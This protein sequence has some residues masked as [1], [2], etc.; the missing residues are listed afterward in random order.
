MI[1]KIQKI[2][3]ARKKCVPRGIE[4]RPSTTTEIESHA[5]TN[6][7]TVGSPIGRG[8]ALYLCCCGRSGF[9]PAWDTFFSGTF[10]FHKCF[11]TEYCNLSTIFYFPFDLLFFLL[12]IHLQFHSLKCHSVQVSSVMYFSLPCGLALLGLRG[13]NLILRYW[14][15]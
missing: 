11:S 2:K 8:V 4:P 13:C 5:S 10:L 6:W 9:D 7:A 3:S 15:L 1:R 12:I 14:D